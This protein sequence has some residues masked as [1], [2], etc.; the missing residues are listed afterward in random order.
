ML[1]LLLI[2][3]LQP[4]AALTNNVAEAA[5]AA[6]KLVEVLGKLEVLPLL[7]LQELIVILPF[8]IVLVLVKIVGAFEQVGPVANPAVGTKIE[9]LRV[10]NLF[11]HCTPLIILIV[12]V[13][14]FTEIGR[15]A[16]A[17]LKRIVVI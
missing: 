10:V 15:Q 2:V 5:P 12:F 1:K 3:S 4:L 8:V 9:K 7:K 13:K 11:G 17:K 16:E 14:S 6:V